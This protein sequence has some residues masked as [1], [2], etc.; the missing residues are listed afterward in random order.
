[1]AS[2]PSHLRRDLSGAMAN[3]PRTTSSYR[4]AHEKAPAAR[5]N[6]AGAAN[7]CQPGVGNRYQ[8]MERL[9]RDMRALAANRSLVLLIRRC[10]ADFIIPK[11]G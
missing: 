1:M 7:E 8:N 9:D 11:S 2:P 10:H 4:A 5:G 3:S 6:G